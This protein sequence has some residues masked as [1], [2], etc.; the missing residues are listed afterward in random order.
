VEDAALRGEVVLVL[1][2]NESCAL[3]IERHGGPPCNS[4]GRPNSNR[5]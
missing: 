5:R 3:R 1:D 4:A 2:Q